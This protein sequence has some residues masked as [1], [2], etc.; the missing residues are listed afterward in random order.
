[1]KPRSETASILISLF[2]CLFVATGCGTQAAAMIEP[3][4]DPATL[5]AEIRPVAQPFTGAA[6]DYDRVLG[7]VG[8]ARFVLLGEA[9]HGTDEF[10][11]TRAEI[12]R[13]LIV[14]GGVDA[15]VVEADWADAERVNRYV[16]GV[17]GDASAEAALGD[18]RRFPTWMWRNTA[19][20]DFVTWLRA[21][22][23]ALPAGARKVRFFGFDLY[24]MRSSK[25]AV[26]AYLERVDPP[27][28]ARARARYAC[29]ERHGAE[30][31]DYGAAASADEA[32]SCAK[33]VAAQTADLEEHAAAY[34]QAG[35]EA[36]DAFFHARQN[37]LVVKDAEVYYR[38]MVS[39][40]VSTWNLRDQHMT[41]TIDA[42]R[43]HLDRRAD[44]AEMVVWAHNSH[45]GDARATEMGEGGEVN[46]GQLVRERYGREAF[47]LGFTTHTGT[48][49]AASSW[50]GTPE[51]K[52]V[53]PSLEE[54]YERVFHDVGL[55]AFLLSLRDGAAPEGLSE[56]RLER[57]IG[58]I[59]HPDTE[60]QSHYFVTTLPEQFD[61][62]IHFDVTR[63]VEP[64]DR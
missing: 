62:I 15:V 45:L 12:T 32:A 47:N 21:H 37:A 14:D 2:S 43:A 41:R 11:R 38:A 8:D 23:D 30:P 39:G 48:V 58:V 18:F 17:P 34:T 52:D 3:T 35:A 13:K 51:R 63:A 19:V 40:G 59:Y 27:A 24:G 50:G 6:S 55:P 53:R 64:L 28:A 31:E 36:E 56:P 25:A 1:M 22:N 61:A 29:L 46:V 4:V 57:A 10:Y 60:R 44:P 16:L 5:A 33:A 54:S 20:R 26:V 49:T 42:I 7:L 9:S